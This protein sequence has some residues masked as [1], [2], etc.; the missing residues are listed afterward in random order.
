MATNPH[1]PLTSADL[2][3]AGPLRRLGTRVFTHETID[4]TN[5]YLLEHAAEAGDGAI[6]WAEFQTAGRGRLGHKWTAPRN[7]SVLLSILLHEPPTSPLLTLGTL[8]GAVAVCEAVEAASDCQPTLRW[9]NDVM[10]GGR[11]LGGVL[12]ESCPLGPRRALVIGVGLNC[13]QQPGHFA[14]EL[15]IKAT[16][17]ECSACRPVDRAGLAAA[18]L[19][20]LDGWLVRVAEP[21]GAEQLRAAWRGRCADFGSRATLHHDGRPFAGTVLDVTEAGDLI[22]QLDEGGR[23]RF[24]AA[25]TTR[26]W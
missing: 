5:E 21:A 3:P 15:A 7:S 8:L 11:K 24:V 18:L 25:T 20:S 1:R 19:Q 16:S 10:A 9:P 14:G 23:R 13:L 26:A 4:S 12:A 2:L 17:L 6:A 22:V